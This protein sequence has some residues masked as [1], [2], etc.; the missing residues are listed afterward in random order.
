MKHPLFS[1]LLMA[2]LLSL[3]GAV[4]AD[5]H[6]DDCHVCGMWI[7]QNLRTRLVITTTAG[8]TAMFCSFACAAR[9]WEKRRAVIQ[10]IRVADYLT[11]ELVDAYSAVYLIG[12]DVP[13]VMS[14]LS[15][16]AFGKRDEALTFQKMHGGMI[17]G[18]TEA[19]QQP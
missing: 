12:S 6:R 5:E 8:D 9:F 13:P 10:Q 19:L 11:T 1:A 18:F 2:V 14:F 7:D 4:Y 3:A 15:I 16:I 17:M